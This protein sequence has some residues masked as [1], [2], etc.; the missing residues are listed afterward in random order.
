MRC[1]KDENKQKEA[2]IVRYFLKKSIK[3]FLRIPKSSL[4]NKG[5]RGKVI[6]QDSHFNKFVFGSITIKL[7][8]PY[9]LNSLFVGGGIL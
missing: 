9:I 7:Y 5:T 2:G 8:Y 4:Q 1:E 3:R 6:L